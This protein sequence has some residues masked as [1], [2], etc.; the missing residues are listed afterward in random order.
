LL[1]R[2]GEGALSLPFEDRELLA[3]VRAQL[4]DKRPEDELRESLRNGRRSQREARRV[5]H[6]LNQGRRTLRLG[7][8]LLVA[9]ALLATAGL[10]LLY[11]RSQKQSLRVY[12]AL[13]KLQTGVASERELLDLVR[14]ARAQGEQNVADAMEAERQSLKQQSK[15]L[16]AKIRQRQPLSG[17]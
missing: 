12:T 5:I 8:L 13:A 7:V 11:W 3:R 9:V 10:G 16:R 2:A 6:A 17:G 14:R 1:P 4:R 15:E